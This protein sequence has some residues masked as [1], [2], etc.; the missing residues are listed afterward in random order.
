VPER[1]SAV[2]PC[3]PFREDL[4][5]VA[6]GVREPP[7]L[8]GLSEHLEHCPVCRAE[9]QT[10]TAAGDQLLLLAPDLEPPGGF[11]ERTTA[12]IHATTEPSTLPARRRPWIRIAA[13]AVVAALAATA[14]AVAASTAH[15]ERRPA[16]EAPAMPTAHL[17]TATGEELGGVVVSGSEPQRLTMWIDEGR[18]GLVVRCDAVLA[19]GSVR[20][21]GTWRVTAGHRSWTVRLDDGSAPVR[22]V[23]VSGADGRMLAV[24]RM[25]S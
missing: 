9:L 22:Q 14:V 24:A 21:V 16:A 13:A 10:L 4:A 11:A 3:G 20:P 18:E 17:V 12:A 5:E 1:L 8:P 25:P 2:G 23:R 6:L 15:D 19:D 7:E